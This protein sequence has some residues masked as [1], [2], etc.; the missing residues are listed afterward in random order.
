MEKKINSEISQIVKCQYQHL[1][2]GYQQ[3]GRKSQEEQNKKHYH[4]GT[5]VSI[6]WKKPHELMTQ[7][8]KVMYNSQIPNAKFFQDY[9]NKF[10]FLFRYTH[11]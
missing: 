10:I 5:E 4:N 2:N 8:Q 6:M 7:N 9:F 1:Q 11:K 3:L